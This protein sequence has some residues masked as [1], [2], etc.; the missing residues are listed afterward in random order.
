[1]RKKL[2]DEGIDALKVIY[3][4]ELPISPNQSYVVDGGKRTVGS[5]SFV[6]SAVGLM[7]ASEVVH[8]IVFLEKK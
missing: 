6:P 7:L 8:D 3:S 1:M 2:R 5:I 4:T